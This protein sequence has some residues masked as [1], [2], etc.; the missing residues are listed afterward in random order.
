MT[1]AVTRQDRSL[2]LSELR[3]GEPRDGA[4]LRP[5]RRVSRADLPELRDLPADGCYWICTFANNQH[6]LKELGGELKETPFYKAIVSPGCLGVVIAMDKECTPFKR[7]WCILE[8]GTPLRWLTDMCCSR[9][10]LS[11]SSTTASST[12]SP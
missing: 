9:S 7:C 1:L 6:D 3:L 4:L 12:L 10:T 8:V 11:T 5:V 2:A